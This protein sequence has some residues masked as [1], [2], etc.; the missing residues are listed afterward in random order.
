MNL[1]H[2]PKS[3]PARPLVGKLNFMFVRCLLFAAALLLALAP[4]SVLATAYTSTGSGGNWNSSAT[5]SPAGVPGSSDTAAIA[6]TAPV[7]VNDAEAATTMT[8]QKGATLTISTGGILTMSGVGIITQSG[9]SSGASTIDLSGGTGMLILSGSGAT[10][11]SSSITL[12]CGTAGSTVEFTYAGAQ[13]MNTQTFDNIIA[14]GGAKSSTITVNGTLTMSGVATL[15]SNP[16]FNA[17]SHLVYDNCTT[18]ATREFTKAGGV[19]DVTLQNG[20]S[21]TLNAAVATTQNVTVNSG[22]TLTLAKA[23]AENT[24]GILSV[25]GIVDATSANNDT[26][27]GTGTGNIE[28]GGVLKMDA[29]KTGLVTTTFPLTVKSGGIVQVGAT[30]VQVPTATWNA[31]STLQLLGAGTL[32]IGASQTFANVTV[33]TTAC[34]IGTACTINGTL[35]LTAGTLTVSATKPTLADG[36]N[37]VRMAGALSGTP[38]FGTTVNVTYND[39]SATTTGTEL[40]TSSTVLNNL[41]NNNAAGLTLNANATINGAFATVYDGSTVPLAVGSHALTLNNNPV[42]IT[43]SGSPIANDANYMIASTSGGLVTGSTQ[44]SLTVNGSGAPSG[45]TGESLSTGTGQLVLSVA[46][47]AAAQL[48][49]ALPGQSGGAGAVSGTPTAQLAGVPFGVTVYAVDAGGF[50]VTSA[51]PT[52]NFTSS[53]TSPSLPGATT[54][55]NGMVTVNVTLNTPGS[56][57]VTATDAASLLTAYQSASVAI[58]GTP[59]LQTAPTPAAITYGQMLSDSSLTGGSCTNVTGAN[60]PG[61]FAYTTPTIAPLAGSTNVSVT[62]T[63]TSGSY[64]TISFNINV[65]VNQ[66]TPVLTNA[67]TASV[68]YLSQ[69]LSNSVLSGGSCTNAAGTIVPGK[70]AFTTPATTPALGTANQS[71]T[72]TPTDTTNYSSISFNVSVTVTAF[73]S[74]TLTT[75][76]TSPWT[77]PPGVTSVTVQMW[78]G[79]GAGGAALGNSTPNG[80]GG[81][82]G[83]GYSTTTLTGLTPGNTIAFSIGAGG[84]GAI[85][86]SGTAGGDTSFTGVTTAGGG[87]GG[88]LATTSTAGTGGT[89][90][91]FNGGAGDIGTSSGG[92]SGGSGAGTNAVGVDASGLTGGVSLAGGGSGGNGTNVSGSTGRAGSA[93]GGGGA[94]AFENGGSARPGGA[95]GNGQI[96]IT[97][98]SGSTTPPTLSVAQSG[99][100]LTFSWTDASFKLQSQTNNLSTGLGS[101]WFDYP[102]NSNPVNVNID[103]ANPSVF[104][105]LSQ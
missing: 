82:G 58:L 73:S 24:P 36:A 39:V 18:T 90:S 68:I 75:S 21:V 85:G 77:I 8:L 98:V 78:G 86:A 26:L 71:V 50:L 66:A 59:I 19:A 6:A 38:T 41:T 47:G 11:I 80:G 69:A 101:N 65:T 92:G 72:F 70:F 2:T 14:S 83:G 4:A 55:V 61:T 56:Q 31:G 89:G 40:P 43:V 27:T 5:W 42:T 33:N 7:T 29:N 15:G 62:F 32:T 91:A 74:T 16:N 30:G 49:V 46:G 35:T 13:T 67:P 88:V 54:L 105:R 10:P 76:S 95:G 12:T 45:A 87:G 28:S 63:P 81:G 52:V 96:V 84:A 60:V 25:S 99:S 37:I 79:G 22:C 94:G 23:L 102:D 103:P 17:G 104:F 3:H 97:A 44:G 57:T 64:G 9:G 34:T 100:T 1:S 51:T 93:P 53:D 48:Q 20:S